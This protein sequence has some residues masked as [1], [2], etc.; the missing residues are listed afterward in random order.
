MRVCLG[1]SDTEGNSSL[2]KD[3]ILDERVTSNQSRIFFERL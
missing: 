2:N 3:K 1:P